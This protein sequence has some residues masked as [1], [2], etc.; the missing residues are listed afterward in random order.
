MGRI[1][2]WAMVVI[3]VAA[4]AWFAID[5]PAG[6]APCQ[7]GAWNVGGDV[8]TLVP[9]A[10]RQPQLRWLVLDGTTGTLAP[11]AD[12]RWRGHRGW[13]DEPHPVTW[14]FSS[15]EAGDVD[16]TPV[17]RLALPVEETRFRGR[18]VDLAGRLVLPPGGEQAPVVVLVHG[19][20]SS[21]A[22]NHSG[23]QYLYPA[24]GIGVFVYDKRGTGA[25]S[26]DYT[27]DFDVLADDAVAALAEARRLA[28]PRLGAIGFEGASQGGWVAPL[29]ATR[30]PV[31]FVL[32]AFGLAISPWEEDQSQVDAELAAT[33]FGPEARAAAREVTRATGRMMATRL[34][35]GTDAL[36][37][38]RRKH[39]D[40]A[41]WSAIRGEYSGD[42]LRY[43]APVLRLALPWFDKGTP[44]R[45]DPMP[46]LRRVRVPMLWILAGDDRD[47]PPQ[48]TIRR[49]DRLAEEGLP[50]TYTVFPGTDHGI[51]EFVTDPEG[52][53][54]RTRYADGYLAMKVEWLRAGGN[55]GL[56]HR[57]TKPKTILQSWDH[58]LTSY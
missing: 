17:T 5:A 7:V 33:G 25:S 41:W 50:T 55:L 37:A 11:G 28:G 26:G 9:T 49:L 12:G 15:C 1:G 42:L 35:E 48:E 43:P 24:H 10:A 38:L 39:G 47:A 34:A 23:L 30:T 27:Q 32:V 18:G 29:A 6:P 20:E 13:T 3:G 40:A 21:S 45:H 57:G 14:S 51:V 4:L 19:S 58:D 8:V 44:W 16:G 22:R 2:R 52:Q 54:T 31:D 56:P 53:R 36:A 46:V